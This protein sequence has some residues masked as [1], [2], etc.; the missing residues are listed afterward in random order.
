M[1]K[2][3][4]DIITKVREFREGYRGK[5]WYIKALPALLFVI[6]AY[7][8]S[9]LD[10][11]VSFSFA[12][13]NCMHRPTLLPGKYSTTSERFSMAY[14]GVEPDSW[15]LFASKLCIRPL[16]APEQNASQSVRAS[17]FGVP[18]LFQ[19]GAVVSVDDLPQVSRTSVGIE[20]PVS[21]P[22][23]L[24]MSS[25]DTTFQYTL[26]VGKDSVECNLESGSQECDIPSMKLAQGKQYNLSIDRSF[27]GKK[28]ATVLSKD[29]TTLDPVVA[30][31]SSIK[32]G[33]TVYTKPEELSID[34][35]KELKKISAKLEKQTGESFQ[36]IESKVSFTDKRALVSFDELDRSSNYRLVIRDVEATDDSTLE[37]QDYIL[38]FTMS[39]GPRVQSINIGKSGVAIGTIVQIRFDQNIHPSQDLSP[40]VKTANMSLLAR[41]GNTLKFSTSGVP[42]CADISVSVAKGLQ[43]E[44]GI[45]ST[46]DWGYSSRTLCQTVISIGSTVKGRAITGYKFGNGPQTALFVGLTHGN[47]KSSYSLLSAWID[48]L[49][50]KAR[51]IP[52]DKSVV[53]IPALSRDGLASGQRR[54]ANNVDLNRNFPTADWKA[55]VTMPGGEMIAGGGGSA[56]LSEPESRAIASYTQSVRPYLA[57]T[58]HAIGGLITPNEAGGSVG[59]AQTYSRV[60]G[61]RVS[62]K[63]QASTTF[64]YDTTGAYEDWLYEKPGIAALLVELSS[65][66]NPHTSRHFP[67][68]W[69]MIR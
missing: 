3:K 57:L 15:Q 66:S 25:V 60:S 46:V 40:L 18:F 38:P 52:A 5:P 56:P 61:Y 47:E 13:E 27:S 69:S 14:E 12:R 7:G 30:M 44:H 33:E 41:Q 58:Y 2:N 4:Q 39:G 51:T 36:A 65:Y 10:R 64:E 34:F 55:D 17:L 28:V 22:L 49:E 19:K 24:R 53:V 50:S 6:V 54:N 42:S 67:A 1:L 20:I 31:A 11:Q 8:A 9:S 59:F 29:V 21:K 48:E 43:S 26:N 32:P 16:M 37:A 35:N 23:R 45:P 62:P 63:S 68:M